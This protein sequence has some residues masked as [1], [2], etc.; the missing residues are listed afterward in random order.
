MILNQN[1][2]YILHALQLYTA[3]RYYYKHYI[4]GRQQRK[5]EK[6]AKDDPTRE[7]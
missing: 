2:T 3:E 7:T 6:K 5:K 1:N 4:H